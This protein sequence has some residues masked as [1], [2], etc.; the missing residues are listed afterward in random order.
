VPGRTDV[1]GPISL[2]I[3]ETGPAFRHRVRMTSV[4]PAQGFRLPMGTI[5]KRWSGPA[6]LPPRASNGD[7]RRSCRPGPGTSVARAHP[8]A[9][10]RHPG[11]APALVPG[12]GRGAPGIGADAQPL[13]AGHAVRIGPRPDDLAYAYGQGSL[14]IEFDFIDHVLEIRTSAGEQRH[15]RLEPRSVAS[16]YTEVMD[17]LSSL[18]VQP[19]TLGRPVEV[20]VAIPFARDDQHRSYDALWARRF[21]LVLLQAHRVMSVFRARFTGKA[22]PVHFFWG[23]GDLAATRFS[24]R[25]APTHPGGVPNCADWVQVLAYSHEVSSCGFWPGGSAEGSFYAYAYPAPDGFADWPVGPSAAFY[26][27]SLGEFL[28]P[29]AAVR[30]ADEPD[31]MLL[32]FFQTSYEAAAELAGWDRAAL[33]APAR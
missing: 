17:R 28:L 9:V 11:H 6:E 1:A 22:S 13:V 24:G 12:R 31:E 33:E 21:W 26:D 8:F 20:P 16:F 7:L 10:G 4:H 25:T 32:E 18:G 29:Y 19:S 5:G 23:G 30:A 15:V 14:E 27:N 3:P 2:R